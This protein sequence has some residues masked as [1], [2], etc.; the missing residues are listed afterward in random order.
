M[1]TRS[2]FTIAAVAALALSPA[3]FA[4]ARAQVQAQVGSIQSGT[5]VV[6]TR[7]AHRHAAQHQGVH[8]T[9]RVQ[10]VAAPATSAATSAVTTP[11]QP[12]VTTPAATSVVT[13]VAPAAMPKD[14]IVKDGSAKDTKVVVPAK[15][16]PAVAT[17]GVT[18][19]TP[20]VRS[21]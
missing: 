9:P 16:A 21:N 6:S 5:H 8:G 19:T 7:S 18:T 17:T 2:V 15:T 3:A 12:A 13:P 20:T 11:A 14:V 10:T 1:R 4:P